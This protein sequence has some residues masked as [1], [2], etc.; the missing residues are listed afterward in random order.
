MAAEEGE[1]EG[2][3]VLVAKEADG[4][5]AVDSGGWERR[6]WSWLVEDEEGEG[7]AFAAGID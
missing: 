6:A 1:G 5:S 3:V 2:D 4:D 7:E